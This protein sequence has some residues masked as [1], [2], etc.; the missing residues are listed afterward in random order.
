MADALMQ[1]LEVHVDYGNDM[2]WKMP[3]D[4]ARPLVH[5]Y[6]LGYP[7]CCYHFTWPPE[8]QHYATVWEGAKQTNVSRYRM[9]FTNMTTMNLD[10]WYVRKVKI[11]CRIGQGVR[12]GMLG[13]PVLCLETESER[14]FRMRA[15]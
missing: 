8:K 13:H 12:V 3:E 10:T 9:N 15:T 2:W 6:R 7:G 11:T 4:I 5:A 1:E 14:Q